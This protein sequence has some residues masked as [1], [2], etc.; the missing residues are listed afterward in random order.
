MWSEDHWEKSSLY[1]MGLS[2][3]IGHGGRHCP[4][5]TEKP[6]HLLVVDLTGYHDVDVR[7]CQCGSSYHDRLKRNQVLRERWYPASSDQPQTAFTFDLL[8]FFFSVS[9]QGKTAAHDYYQAVVCQSNG[10][11]LIKT[12]VSCHS[13]MCRRAS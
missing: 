9:T 13:L 10:S 2:V 3:Q 1:K 5:A 7:F 6:Y 12:P 11:R 4:T 8:K